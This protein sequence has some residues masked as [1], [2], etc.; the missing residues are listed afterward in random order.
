LH[1]TIVLQAQMQHL[2]S[3]PRG[4]VT[5]ECEVI[6]GYSHIDPRVLA[7]LQSTALDQAVE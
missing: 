1:E 2:E 4:N 3:E 5:R 7:S 6:A